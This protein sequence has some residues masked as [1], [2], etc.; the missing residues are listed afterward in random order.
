MI[1]YKSYRISEH[2]RGTIPMSL[3]VPFSRLNTAVSTEMAQLPAMI[4]GALFCAGNRL[5]SI[6]LCWGRAVHQE[7]IDSKQVYALQGEDAVQKSDSVPETELI[8]S[9]IMGFYH[10]H[11][12]VSQDL[13]RAIAQEKGAEAVKSL[14]YVSQL[15]DDYRVF[16]GVASD[17][18]LKGATRDAAKVAMD[19]ITAAW[20]RSTVLGIV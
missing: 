4:G 6:P 18:S 14:G 8:F 17:R 16:Q 9:W 3:T 11:L 1:E 10:D 5:L 13:W 2:H 19:A 7:R 20:R 15:I 12:Q